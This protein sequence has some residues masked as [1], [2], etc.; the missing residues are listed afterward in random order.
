MKQKK[1]KSMRVLQLRN[2]HGQKM[3]LYLSLL[4]DD[5]TINN[6][7]TGVVEYI[8][9]KFELGEEIDERETFDELLLKNGIERVFAD[10]IDT[11]FND[12]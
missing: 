2:Q 5:D 4:Q 6:V 7:I 11:D 3:G 12:V 10:N 8:T 9:E 1:H